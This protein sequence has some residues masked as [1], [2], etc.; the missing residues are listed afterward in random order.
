MAHARFQA[1]P[2]DGFHI[3]LDLDA[4]RYVAVP[5]GDAPATDIA[6]MACELAAHLAVDASDVAIWPDGHPR[7]LPVLN[8]LGPR[9]DASRPS[10]GD[11]LAL[12]PAALR[13]LAELR[14]KPPRS[15]LR[16]GAD[17]GPADADAV[18]D[19]ARRFRTMRPFVPGLTRCLPHALLL[20]AFLERLD[21]PSTLVIGVRVFPFEAHSWVQ[22]GS[23]VLTD[24]FERLAGFTAI[25]AG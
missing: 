11:W 14:R 7:A 21:Q 9:R 15:W 4:D 1:V 3:V 10:A 13:A 20:R 2:L 5:R 17:E 12:A 23:V 22:A 18:L 24:D 16:P 25:V 8:D 19:A 6:A